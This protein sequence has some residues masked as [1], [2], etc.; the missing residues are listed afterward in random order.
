[1]DE[2]TKKRILVAAT[3]DTTAQE[4]L[5]LAL[6]DIDKGEIKV[7]G[8]IILLIN[9][10][11]TTLQQTTYRAG[12]SKDQEIACLEIAKQKAVMKFLG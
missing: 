10:D 4:I 1:M 9:L 5:Q 11:A 7:T 6:D 2:F 8:A 3:S 12:V